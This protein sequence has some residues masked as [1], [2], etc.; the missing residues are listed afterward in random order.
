MLEPPDIAEP[1]ERDE[2]R[3][4]AIVKLLELDQR[5]QV[6]LQIRRSM[7]G[8][9]PSDAR[10]RLMDASRRDD[11]I[12]ESR[13]GRWV[14]IFGDDIETIHDTRSRVIHGVRVPDAQIRG[15]IWLGQQ[16]LNLLEGTEI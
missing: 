11:D 1:F 7:S 5:I 16:I 8:E 15:A 2:E 12:P 4:T 13:L 6:W 9:L 10:I 3:A 14:T